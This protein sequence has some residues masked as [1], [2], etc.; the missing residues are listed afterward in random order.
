M[1]T[2]VYV[3]TELATEL[4]EARKS[5]G[6]RQEDLAVDD[7]L[8]T[9]TISRMERGNVSV[10]HEKL[11]YLG[12][13]L[14]VPIEHNGELTPTNNTTDLSL[15][16]LSIENQLGMISTDEAWEEL[17]KIQAESNFHQMWALYLKGKYWERKQKT[18]KAK[19]CYLQVAENNNLE[20][21]ESNLSPAAYHALGR[22]AFYEEQMK[23]A[24]TYVEKGLERFHSEGERPHIEHML[25]ISKVIYLERLERDTEALLLIEEM[26]ENK[27]NMESRE[28]IVG[29][30]DMKTKLLVKLKRFD[31]AIPIAKKGLQVARS[32][33]MYDHACSLWIEL[34]ECYCQQNELTNAKVCF[35]SSTSMVEKM[36]IKFLVIQA[37]LR[38]GKLYD[39]KN[40][41]KKA[42]DMY[43]SAIKTSRKHQD[44]LRLAIS[45]EHLG[46]HYFINQQ[47]TKALKVY[48]EAA[49]IY[50]DRNYLPNHCNILMK[51]A[52]IHY[53]TNQ[54]QYYRLLDQYYQ[55]YN[56]DR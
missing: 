13:R 21:K 27:D 41:A 30:Y 52:R 36:R 44:M 39:Q 15:Q 16:L 34:G 29:M 5:Q 28:V 48:E 55:A 22:I 43:Q 19:L 40:N 25:Q 17:R 56:F 26:W 35:R 7:F 31:E 33:Q 54:E 50:R 8:S 3:T 14:A 4:R 11:A 20:L 1:K 24:L 10:S 51:L 9:G 32:N 46:D 53:S 47:K 18:E 12:K 45:L 49:E 6:L 23:E 2:H 42:F 38:L 37:F